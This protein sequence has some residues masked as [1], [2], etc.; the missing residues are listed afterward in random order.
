[1]ARSMRAD[2]SP[3]NLGRSRRRGRRRRRADDRRGAGQGRADH[4]RDQPVAL[5]RQLPQDGRAL[6][7]GDRQ[8]GRA[9]RQPVRRLAREAA[10]LGARR[11]GPVRPPDHELG[12]V[13]RDVFRRLRRGR[14]AT[15]I[16]ASSSTR[17]ST[18]SATRSTSIAAKKTMTPAGKLMSMP[19]SPL[20][21]D[22]LLP[23]R[24]LQGGRAQGARDLRRAR[25]QRAQVPQAAAACTASSSA[26]R[27]GRTPSPTTSI[28]TSTAIGGGIFKRPG[29]GRLLGHAEQR[30]G[31]AALDYYIR[32][33]QRGRPSED[34]G[35]RPGR[36]DPEHGHG[37]ERP[38][39]DGDR[40]LVADGRPRP[41]RPSSTRSSS[42]RRRTCQGVPPGP[43]LGHWLGGVA[44][45]VPDDR[46]R[47]A[48]EFLR[49]F[50]TKDAQ[51]ATAKAGGIPVSAAAYRD[52]I[53]EER[54]YRWMKPLADVA[55]ARR[56]HL[57][58][59][60]GERGH[61][62]PGAR[63]QPGHRRRDHVSARP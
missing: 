3:A 6:R 8:Q 33:A 25:G 60:G 32:L 23:R 1:M 45:N 5:V 19:I 13:R 55:A 63:P 47:A 15:S 14:S 44:Q 48:V 20:D 61:R 34:R 37:Q 50:Q 28:P 58:V 54:K 24:P 35:A 10:Q 51:I 4:D 40:G 53:A 21:P 12:L 18:R 43:G 62:H 52:P 16:P 26:A 41:S 22:A 17:T 49:W 57:P 9:R 31:K 42:R 39:H 38:H 29:G 46:K 36:G 27:A 59:P 56:Q 30:E 2:R 7:E 11:P